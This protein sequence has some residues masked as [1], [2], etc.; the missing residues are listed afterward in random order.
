MNDYVELTHLHALARE[1]APS[2]ADGMRMTPLERALL[3]VG[4]SA[5]I[6]SLNR[7]ALKACIADAYEKGASSAQLQEV[8]SLVSGLGVHSL[9]IS[10]TE[11]LRGADSLQRVAPLTREQ[12]DLW[13]QHVG[14]SSFWKAFE[15][16]MP[17]F[18]ESMLRLS[19]DQFTAFFEY[20]AVPWKSHAIS[21]RLKELIAMATD[22]VPAH[23]FLPGFRLHLRNAIKL[24]ATR[25][26]IFE[27]LDVAAFAP[28]HK[29]TA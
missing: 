21:A 19:S 18:L 25:A 17:G 6:A 28:P 22:A 2:E 5:S 3:C 23:R 13:K 7:E 12:Q 20:C 26:M 9:M 10:S 1:L 8:V 14:D 11:I 15:H 4:V 29:G 16:E 24:G 27:A